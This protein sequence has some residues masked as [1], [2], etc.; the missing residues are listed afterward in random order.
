MSEIINKINEDSFNN[1][2]RQKA[3]Y[4]DRVIRLEDANR[5]LKERI[6]SLETELSNKDSVRLWNENEGLKKR[7][8]ELEVEVLILN[9]KIDL[10]KIKALGE[11]SNG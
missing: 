10:W 9:Q 5:Y 2:L 1:L 4:S 3:E 6:G 11:V 7:I 8:E